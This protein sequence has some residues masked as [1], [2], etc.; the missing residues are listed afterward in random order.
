MPTDSERK[1]AINCPRC[2]RD[3]VFDQPY[4]YHAGFSD[5]GFMYSESGHCTLVWSW[6]DPAYKRFF[7]PGGKFADNIERQEK[8][9]R[10][11]K[12]APDGGKWG[13]NNPARCLYCS[14]PISGTI[15]QHIYYLVYPDSIITDQDGRLDLNLQ[16]N[17]AEKEIANKNTP[18]SSKVGF[19]QRLFGKKKLNYK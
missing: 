18:V 5:Q 4:P 7:P 1:F 9:E 17:D 15:L 6:F 3:N 13:F 10:C 14:G 11:L 19:W 12:S 2:R 8:F 16:L